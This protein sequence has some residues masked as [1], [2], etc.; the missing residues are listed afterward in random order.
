MRVLTHACVCALPA[1]THLHALRL[2]FTPHTQHS[3][4]HSQTDRDP[5]M[6]IWPSKMKWKRP[7]EGSVQTSSVSSTVTI[8]SIRHTPPL[9]HLL[10]SLIAFL[11]SS[12]HPLSI[13]LSGLP[14]K[15]DS[16]L[17]VIRCAVGFYGSSMSETPPQPV[18]GQ[19]RPTLAD[20]LFLV[21]FWSWASFSLHFNF[22]HT[23]WNLS[24]GWTP[25]KRV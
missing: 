24:G 10:F 3:P 19:Q 9:H 7:L 22:L 14:L 6:W 17:A 1:L 16:G 23:E 20:K 18:R 4:T 25:D 21:F 5:L 13:F 2:A 11:S 15:I 12:V 8:L